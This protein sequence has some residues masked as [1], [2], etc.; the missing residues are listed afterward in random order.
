MAHP[1]SLTADENIHSRLF[2]PLYQH[3]QHDLNR[4]SYRYQ[5]ERQQTLISFSLKNSQSKPQLQPQSQPFKL[6]T[7]RLMVIF[8]P[9]PSSA[10]NQHQHLLPQTCIQ[11]P[12]HSPRLLRT[13]ASRSSIKLAAPDYMFSR[14]AAHPASTISHLAGIR[15]A[16]AAIEG[17]QRQLYG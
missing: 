15:A 9:S 6:Q 16:K 1:L 11:L 14:F 2:K 3:P 12:E 5:R 17:G 4:C 10:P 13:S 7:P 8:P